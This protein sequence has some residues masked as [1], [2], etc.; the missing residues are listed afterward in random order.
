M[1]VDMNVNVNGLRYS[2]LHVNHLSQWFDSVKIAYIPPYLQN[3]FLYKE[4]DR[5]IY[6]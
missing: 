1:Y 5:P 6:G 4:K 2:N 3:Q